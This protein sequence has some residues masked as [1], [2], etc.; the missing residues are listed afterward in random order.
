MPFA[1]P[2]VRPRT[3]PIKA[4]TVM[5][6]LK[7]EPVW[8]EIKLPRR[9]K[10]SGQRRF[11]VVIVG[12]GIT[13][14][15]AAWLLKQAGKSV[16]VLERDRVGAVDTGHTT[17]HLTM[18]TDLR[19]KSLVRQFGKDAARLTWQGGAAAIK[20]IHGIAEATGADCEFRRVPG[21][22]H[23][24]LGGK[25]DESRELK[26][27]AELA[28]ELGFA[29]EFVEHVPYFARPGIRF[30]NQAKFHPL[31]YLAA[32]ARAIPGEGSA[33]FEHAEATEITA[34]EEQPFKV[35]AGSGAALGEFLV[36]ATHV[37]LMGVTSL[38]PATL[39]QTKI[40][41][42][43]SY[44]VGGTAPKGHLPE[45]SFW[46]TSD[47]YF[48]LRVD[49]GK[50]SD[51]VIFGGLDHK[52]G[53]VDESQRFADLRAKLYTLIPEATLDHQ[54]SGQVIETNDGLP[55][56]GQTAERQFVATGFAGNG[57]TLG[58][59]GAMMACDAVLGRENPWQQ[60][61]SVDRKQLRGGTWDYLTENLDYPYYL[62]ADRLTLPKRASSSSLARG[63][64]RVLTSNGQLI[65]CSRDERGKLTQVSAVCTHMGCLV[66]WNDA[67]KTWDCPCHG[68]RFQASGE[69][70]AGP[71][72]SPL[73]PIPKSKL[74]AVPPAPASK[75][76]DK[77]HAKQAVRQKRR[78]TGRQTTA[79]RNR[80]R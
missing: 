38:L 39:F 55:Y 23:A 15:T 66:H 41:P 50:K 53:Q 80:G 44:V 32:L 72:E 1:R 46:D 24:A 7:T 35:E 3:S 33:V 31:K 61:F 58:T 56:I 79:R 64:G 77:E 13:G 36:I 5:T 65:A 20:T 63:E 45:A 8:K 78:S 73:E 68:S 47:P 26:E 2:F 48:Y 49:A 76:T 52:T 59:L 69:V 74:A 17:A 60:L 62:V 22:L 19:L 51:Y 18:V 14:L 71:A 42:Y 27:E 11:D 43:T 29:A 21:F 28:R 37:P 4:A 57:M 70:L 6:A 9:A 12:G 30:P 16:A 10:L 54:W 25:R 67:E 40:Y 75:R 34:E